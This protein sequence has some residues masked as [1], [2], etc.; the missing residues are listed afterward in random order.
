MEDIIYLDSDEEIPSAIEK[1]KQSKAKK[2]ALV[3]QKEAGILQSIVNLKL[4]KNEAE[5]L[6]KEIALVTHDEIGRNLANQVGIAVYDAPDQKKPTIVASR[7][8]P[9]VKDEVIEVDMTRKQIG[10]NIVPKG[11][12]VHD[13][14]QIKDE[15]KKEEKKESKPAKNIFPKM[16]V[17]QILSILAV[18]ILGIYF[19]LPKV[20]VIAYVNFQPL[21][22]EVEVTLPAKNFS[23]VEE[24]S[25]KFSATGKKNIGEKAKGTLTLYNSWDTS[26]QVIAAGTSFK[27]NDGKVFK[28]PSAISIPGAS[29][30]LSQGQVSTTPGKATVNIEAME[31][32]E[33]YNGASGHFTITSIAPEK[34]SKIYAETNQP[35]SG[36]KNIVV[37]VV[38]VGDLENAKEKL[39]QEIIKSASE[40]INNE[41]K[42]LKVAAG[43]VKTQFLEETASAKADD[44]VKEFEVKIKLRMDALGFE[45]EKFQNEIIQKLSEELP[46]DKE[47]IVTNSDEVTTNIKNADFDNKKITIAGLVKTKIV[48]KWDEKNIRKKLRNQ[49]PVEAKIYLLNLDGVESAKIEMKP[50]WWPGRL[51]VWVSRIE[52]DREFSQ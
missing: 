33:E 48:N 41:G 10:E 19:F 21:E 49:S 46:E 32:G 17:W 47:L 7:P 20:K 5:K 28:N 24:K 27:S 22:K 40:K 18:L 13:Y 1:I 29:V 4:I 6:N 38:S 52:L 25:E 34:Q 11:L 30:G 50:S 14:R 12:K 16:K 3:A 39:K 44:Q 43:S 31:P 36:G 15:E 23:A 8:A 37:D 45:E 35:I 2:I 51:P 9:S 42:G 26:T